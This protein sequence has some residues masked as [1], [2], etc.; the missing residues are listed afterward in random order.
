MKFPIDK[1]EWGLS[2]L[3]SIFDAGITELNR[4]KGLV[5]LLQLDDLPAPASVRT[6]YGRATDKISG[7]ARIPRAVSPQDAG[8]QHWK[9]KRGEDLT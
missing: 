5:K 4:W 8:Q 3:D 2:S 1:A 6:A 7:T 9:Q